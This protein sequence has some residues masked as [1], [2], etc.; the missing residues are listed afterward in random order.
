MKLTG[1]QLVKKY[2]AFCGTQTF[3]TAFTRVRHLYLSWAT[4]IQSMQP[5]LTSWKSNLISSYHLRLGLL[6]GLFPSGFPT[7][8]PYSPLLSTIRATCPT[9]LILLDFITRTTLG[10]QY[11]SLSLSLWSFLHSPFISS[12]L[13]PNI[14]LNTL[15]SDILSLCFSLN[16]SDQVSHTYKTTDKII[17]IYVNRYIF[18]YQEGRQKI[19]HRMIASIPW[20][21]SALNF[22]LNRILNC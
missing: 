17:L 10:E 9:H 7:K 20:L 15:F 1:S 22:F 12:L 8:A 4:S 21:L 19:L 5:I 11:K 16:V 18:W 3:I 14:L 2:P 13:G 6:C